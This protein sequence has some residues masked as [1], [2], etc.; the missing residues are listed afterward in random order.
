MPVIS[1]EG[2]ELEQETLI[3]LRFGVLLYPH[4]FIGGYKGLVGIQFEAG[5][6]HAGTSRRH[7]GDTKPQ[8]NPRSS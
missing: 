7:R 6:G 8:Q 1:V 2:P 5:S 3:F 4:G